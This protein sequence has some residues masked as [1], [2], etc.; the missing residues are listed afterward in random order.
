MR[1]PLQTPLLGHWSDLH[2]RKPFFFVAQA[3]AMERG[4]WLCLPWRARAVDAVAMPL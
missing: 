4:F 1:L 2:G 3:S